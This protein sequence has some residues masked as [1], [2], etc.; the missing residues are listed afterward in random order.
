METQ[1]EKRELILDDYNY[2]SENHE[3][4][5]SVYH[6]DDS[7][8]VPHAVFDGP[9]ALELA[10]IYISLNAQRDY[11]SSCDDRKLSDYVAGNCDQYG[12]YNCGY[13]FTCKY[14]LT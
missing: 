3:G 13:C 10:A 8:S 14:L 6:E 2:D 9:D 7:C 12:D 1:T 11:G 4:S 5:V